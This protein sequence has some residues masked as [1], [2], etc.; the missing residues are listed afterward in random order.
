MW[1]RAFSTVSRSLLDDREDVAGGEH[2]VLFAGVLDLGAAVLRVEHRLADLDVDRD[3]VALVV[4]AAG[5]DSEDG[6][7]LR[8]L[9][10]G[11]GDHDARRR[12]RLSLVRLDHDAVLERLDR[13]LCRGSHGHPLLGTGL[14]AEET[15]GLMPHATGR[16]RRR[17]CR[18]AWRKRGPRE[19][20]HAGTLMVR[21]LIGDY[22]GSRT[23]SNRVP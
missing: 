3:A 15:A 9:L 20:S 2:Q 4:D 18:S 13:N 21:V 23:P 22:A 14:P 16:G 1:A 6:G 10:G 11:V 19:G 17:G 8:L 12:G 5:A 7:P